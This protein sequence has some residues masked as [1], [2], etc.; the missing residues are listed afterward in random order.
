MCFEEGVAHSSA[1]EEGVCCRDEVGDDS[2]FV[3]YFGSAE[4][5][6]EWVLWVGEDVVE[7]GDFF[8]DEESG[9]AWEELCNV[10]DACLFAVN[11]AESIGDKEVS[12]LCVFVGEV[13]AFVVVAFFFAVE[14]YVF[15]DDDVSVVHGV[16]GV[17]DAWTVGF[18][19]EGDGM[20]KEFSK[21]CSN[22][23]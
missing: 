13:L 19:D 4:N 12:K 7:V 15:E 17:E 6:G 5:D 23:F 18:V 11:D 8:L 3:G 21:A 2:D 22:G 1:D 20:V 16:D 14:S 10:V 9:C